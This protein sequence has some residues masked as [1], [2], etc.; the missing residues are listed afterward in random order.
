MAKTFLNNTRSVIAILF[1]GAVLN[2]ILFFA[3][4]FL[5]KT[6]FA[7]TLVFTVLM[8]LGLFALIFTI[9]YGKAFEAK[10]LFL[11]FIYTVIG[12]VCLVFMYFML[13]SIGLTDILG[14]VILIAMYVGLMALIFVRV[15]KTP[16]GVYFFVW[17]F[18]IAL[19][20]VLMYK[21]LLDDIQRYDYGIQFLLSIWILGISM[22]CTIAVRKIKSLMN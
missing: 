10:K 18:S 9:A 21:Y 12:A 19:F 7:R 11:S 4:S 14:Y 2:A 16:I 13:I 15:A 8:Y 3:S 1:C 17:H 5:E 22:F 20:A 6:V